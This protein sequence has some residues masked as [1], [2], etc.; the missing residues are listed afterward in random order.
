[1]FKKLFTT[2]CML[3]FIAL[4]FTP[5]VYS[6]QLGG[7]FGDSFEKQMQNNATAKT[8]ME[9]V[10]KYLRDNLLNNEENAKALE[11]KAKTLMEHGELVTKFKDFVIVEYTDFVNRNDYSLYGTVFLPTEAYENPNGQKYPFVFIAY[12]TMCINRI[13]GILFR[14]LAKNGYIV[15]A[16]DYQGQGFSSGPAPIENGIVD[17]EVYVDDVLE[18]QQ[19]LFDKGY[20]IDENRMG[21]FG[22]SLGTMVAPGVIHKD[23]RYRAVSQLGVLYDTPAGGATDYWAKY[24]D[25]IDVPLQISMAMASIHDGWII[26]PWWDQAIELFENYNGEIILMVHDPGPMAPLTV[27]GFFNSEKR[28]YH[29]INEVIDFY[30]YFLNGDKEAYERLIAPDPYCT[31]IGKSYK[32]END[33]R[34]ITEEEWDLINMIRRAAI[35]INGYPMFSKYIFIPMWKYLVVPSLSL[36]DMPVEYAMRLLMPWELIWNFGGEYIEINHEELAP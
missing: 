19:Y 28:V 17:T 14:E 6:N 23:P 9:H 15:A 11:E 27:A 36:V 22:W 25:T 3:V 30:D 13:Y 7:G 26:T 34:L 18:F 1:M 4:F 10:F 21:I 24:I 33:Q 32:L 2:V 12:G 16:I 35:Y 8:P 5:V 20:P 31:I 29:Y